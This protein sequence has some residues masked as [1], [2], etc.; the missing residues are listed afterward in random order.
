MIRK[1]NN[2]GSTHDSKTHSTLQGDTSAHPETAGLRSSSVSRGGNS[3]NT[4]KRLLDER[5]EEAS[6][7]GEK[8]NNSQDVSMELDPQLSPAGNASSSIGNNGDLFGKEKQLCEKEPEVFSTSH[9]NEGMDCCP[10]E[11]SGSNDPN[12]KGD[13]T[14][15]NLKADLDDQSSAMTSAQSESAEKG[16]VREN[17]RQS[18]QD[19][20]LTD[21]QDQQLLQHDGPDV[22]NEPGSEADGS[23]QR[24]QVAEEPHSEEAALILTNQNTVVLDGSILQTNGDKIQDRCDETRKGSEMNDSRVPYAP[25]HDPGSDDVVDETQCHKKTPLISETAS[26]Q[27]TDIQDA[28]CLQEAKPKLS[29]STVSSPLHD[30][31]CPTP[32][33]DEEPYQ[34]TPCSGPSSSSTSSTS[35]VTGGETLTPVSQ[36]FADQRLLVLKPK[37]PHNKK[38]KAGKAVK[39]EANP[40]P[41]ASAVMKCKDKL[42]SAQNRTEEYSRIGEKPCFQ[43]EKPQSITAGKS[44]VLSLS[45]CLSNRCLQP[46]KPIT[47]KDGPKKPPQTSVEMPSCSQS[48]VIPANITESDKTQG[49]STSRDPKIEN[50]KVKLSK[51]SINPKTPGLSEK[52]TKNLE[53]QDKKWQIREESSAHPTT[54]SLSNSDRTNHLPADLL[55]QIK[56]R[57]TSELKRVVQIIGKEPRKCSETDE[58]H[59]DAS[60]RPSVDHSDGA[61]LDD[62]FCRG[63]QASLRCTIF[64]S[65]RKRSSTFL[66]Q[67]SKR[68]L[69]EDL[70]QASVEEECLIF[71]EQMKQVL[72]RSKE[73]SIRGRTPDTRGN[74]HLFRSSFAAARCSLQGQEG[75]PP[76]FVGLKIT[77]DVSERTSQTDTKEEEMSTSVKHAGVSG[78]RAGRARLDTG[79]TDDGRKGPVRQ[80]D[81]RT[82]SGHPKTEP[83]HLS[84]ACV[85]QESFPKKTKLDGKS[86]SKTKYRFYILATSD[87]PC[88]EK[89]KVRCVFIKS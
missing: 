13:T 67:M 33:L 87:D 52:R 27:P 68:C 49:Q 39:S 1:A 65:S 81:V 88:F 42:L 76:S 41:S 8:K 31:R 11:D 62:A 75:D 25:P 26:S 2:I 12:P 23:Q 19:F 82:D 64:N 40:P 38:H 89:T 20:C 45:S 83:G 21:V 63:P 66:E 18:P 61:L 46:S 35:I 9:A 6:G 80:K 34:Y 57:D 22:K 7:V 74:V 17:N 32:T 56:R 84:N 58:K 28:S 79:R 85:K 15:S 71:S 43:R 51:T 30:D 78:V 54:T 10:S 36:K 3:E 77:V 55:R 86:C 29:D 60:S 50:S 47:D 37:I 16:P 70:T 14:S 72:K 48:L 69:Q 59:V 24:K 44:T 5:D 53:E 4:L 73:K